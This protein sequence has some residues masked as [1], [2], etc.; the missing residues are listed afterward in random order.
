MRFDLLPYRQPF[1]LL[2]K[3]RAIRPTQL[4]ISIFDPQ[5]GAF[6]I[7]RKVMVH[8]ARKLRL[9]LPIVSEKV[10]VQIV[11]KDLPLGDSHYVIENVKIVRDTKCPIELTDRDKRFIKLAKWFALEVNQLKAGE[12]GTIYQSEEFNLLL[13]DKIKENGKELSTPARIGQDTG[14][15]Q[16]SKT[17]IQDYTVPMLMVMLLHEY[18]HHFKNPEYGRAIE[19]EMSADLI[20]INMALNLGFD[21]VEVEHCFISV[22][23]G[24][25]TRLNKK[26]LAAIREFIERFKSTEQKRCNT[27]RRSI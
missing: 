14:I 11:N 27:K 19:N 1:N 6:F 20:A 7:D 5:S 3:I 16:V 26:R 15:I 18:A 23:N 22:F 4:L 12:K 17:K 13:L 21:P 9:K 8:K 10:R 2:L 25:K 24:K